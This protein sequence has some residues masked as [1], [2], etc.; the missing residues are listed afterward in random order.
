MRI[1]GIIDSSANITVI[2]HIFMLEPIQS[3]LCN[4]CNVSFMDKAPFAAHNSKYHS[5]STSFL[6]KLPLGIYFTLF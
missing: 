1:L 5:K 3:Y 2:T 4:V 6:H